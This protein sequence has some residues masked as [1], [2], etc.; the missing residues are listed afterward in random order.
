MVLL[1]MIGS[2]LIIYYLAFDPS[3]ILKQIKLTRLSKPCQDLHYQVQR[4][5]IGPNV[6]LKMCGSPSSSMGYVQRMRNNLDRVI[7]A[8]STVYGSII[9]ASTMSFLADH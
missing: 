6:F 5:P 3:S 4:F 1:Y 2:I 7:P 9:N 8:C